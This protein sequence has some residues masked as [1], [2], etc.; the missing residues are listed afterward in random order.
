M[1]KRYWT[2]PITVISTSLGLSGIDTGNIDLDAQGFDKILVGGY[3]GFGATAATGCEARLHGSSDGGTHY[4]S[5]P[6]HVVTVAMV[7]GATVSV[8]TIF[9]D[10]PCC[11]IVVVNLDATQGIGVLV[12]YQGHFE[13]PG[14]RLER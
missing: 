11:Q 6:L 5:I 2:E 14:S 3:V 10:S 8:G 13:Y 12:E 4:H 7:T 9:K 1:D